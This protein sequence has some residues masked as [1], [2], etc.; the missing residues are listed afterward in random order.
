MKIFKDKKSLIKEISNYKNLSFVPTM[1]SLHKGHI[2][3]IKKAKK[4]RGKIIVSIYVNPK[5][6]NSK[7]D[8][9]KYPKNL[10]KDLKILKK[11]KI[12]YLYLPSTNDIY[13]FRSNLPIYL[14]RFSKK[15]CGKFRPGHFKGVVNVVNRF[16][17]IIK[18]RYMFLGIKDLQQLIL[19]KL[20]VIKNNIKTIIIPCNTVRSS[21]GIALS[22]R[23]ARLNN[24]QKKIA[25]KVVK[26]LKKNKF[27]LIKNN[28]YN[29]KKNLINKIINLGVD[30]VDYLEALNI[31][32]FDVIKNFKD[33]I[34]IAYHLGNVRLIDNL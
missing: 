17:Q 3:L 5:Q 1:G 11:E 29:L 12:D 15:L 27:K 2:S 23:N 21:S 31:K 14:H 30:K 28:S 18:P 7:T 10:T 6:F 26:F 8:F 13:N 4:K 34:F 19:L 16:L 25:S 32:K 9:K 24:N 22:S 33:K 20:H